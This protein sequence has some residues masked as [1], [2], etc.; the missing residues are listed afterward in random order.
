MSDAAALTYR[1]LLHWRQRPVSIA[2]TL[3]F[4]V[5]ITLMFAYLFGGAM[6]VPDGTYIDFFIPGMLAMTVLFG[7]ESMAVAVTTDMAKGVTDRIRAMPVTATAVLAGRSGADLLNAVAGLAV[8]LATGFALGWRPHH[9]PAAFLTALGLLLWLRFA[10]TW[11]GIYL[12]LLLRTPESATAVQILVWPIGFLS[13]A[14]VSPGTMPGWLGAIATW[15]PLSATA[16]AARTLFA[17][18]AWTGP[19]WPAEHAVLLAVLWPAVLTALFLPLAAR[20]Y[21]RLAR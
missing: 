20:Q 21:H 3:L 19:T 6:A 4:P 12:G 8:M 17:G 18:P 14:F 11:V 5:L 7:L 9:G 10:F 13:S 15:N 16:T 2:L 1:I